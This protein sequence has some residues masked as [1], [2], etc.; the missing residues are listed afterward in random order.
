IFAFGSANMPEADS[1][2]IGG[3][4]DMTKKIAFY[5][6]TPS[7]GV[8]IVSGTTGDTG[9]H[10][11]IGYRDATGVVQLPVFATTNGTVVQANVFSTGTIGCER[12]LYGNIT[13]AITGTFPLANP[14][15]TAATGDIAVLAHTRTL[16]GRTAQVG[17]AN[18]SGTTPPLFKLQATDGTAINA[19]TFGGAGMI[20]RITGGTGVN[21]LRTISV[22]YTA[23]AYGTDIVAINRDWV[24]IP[25]ATSTYD[26]AQ[27][28]LFDI[29]PSGIASQTPVTAITR[30]F[31][32]AQADIP[33]NPQRIFYEKVFTANINATIALTGATIQI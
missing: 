3:A 26:I 14:G 11:Q 33:G 6:I 17:S 23:G 13:G 18:T 10:V 4:I 21:Q 28:F 7:G 12:L 30:C 29:L 31:A 25:D 19:L 2:S 24:T 27:G 20:I 8:D 16:T 32:T 1:A 5:D 22:P 9:V 15:G